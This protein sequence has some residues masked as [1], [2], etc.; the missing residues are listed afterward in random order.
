MEFFTDAGAGRTV[1]S[2]GTPNLLAYLIRDCEKDPNAVAVADPQTQYT[3][4][5]LLLFAQKTAKLLGE[6][7]LR[8]EPIAVLAD[9]TAAT[10]ALF[11]GV[12]YSGN[13]YV[14]IDPEMPAQKKQAIFDDARFPAVLGREAGGL[15][16]LRYAGAFF[17]VAD[18]ERTDPTGAV[19]PQISEDAPA[20]LIY[21]SGSTGT[22]KGVL[23]SHR[24]VL[25]FIESFT[26]TFAFSDREV[27]GNPTPS[28]GKRTGGMPSGTG[29][30]AMLWRTTARFTTSIW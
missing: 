17:T 4:A 24:A 23:K 29:W 18:V 8:G 12:L 6:M 22:P 20:Y 2:D 27:I 25:R 28:S 21:T 11:L 15:E 9:R 30:R 10:V 13:Y 16:A 5:Q 3:Y 14:P 26:E 19:L 7:G 1:R